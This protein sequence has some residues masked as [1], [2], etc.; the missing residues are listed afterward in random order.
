VLETRARPAD[1]AQ[2]H[3]DVATRI[4][5]VFGLSLADVKFLPRGGIPRTTSGKRQRQRL[6]EAY[7]TGALA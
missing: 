7:L 5:Q 4:R 2:I 6:R 1:R 3:T